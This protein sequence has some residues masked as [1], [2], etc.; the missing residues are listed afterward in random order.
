MRLSQLD[1]LRRQLSVEETITR[2]GGKLGFGPPKTKA[3]IR[4]IS[5]P[6]F[7][8]EALAVHLAEH[9]TED[10]VFGSMHPSNF[11]QRVWNPAV[12][13]TV[14]RPCRFHDYADLR[15]MPTSYGNSLSA[16]ASG[17]MR[18]A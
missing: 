12:E 17:P 10:L 3:S 11:R 1:Q 18:S 7:V 4:R 13:A 5:L 2:V 15:V 16:A 14:G 6:A 8:V 9:P